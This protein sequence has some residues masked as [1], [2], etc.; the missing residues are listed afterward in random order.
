MHY[1]YMVYI[2]LYYVCVCVC[3]LYMWFIYGGTTRRYSPIG[4]GMALLE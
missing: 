1:I 2:C 4:V 3:V